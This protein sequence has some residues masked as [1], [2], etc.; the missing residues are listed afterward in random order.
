MNVAKIK[1]KNL[2]NFTL[3]LNEIYGKFELY[4]FNGILVT[5]EKNFGNLKKNF[6]LIISKI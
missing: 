2:G 4:I 6:S 1:N 3:I 5:F